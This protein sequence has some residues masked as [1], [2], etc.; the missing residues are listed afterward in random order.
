ML[1][2]H[3]QQYNG[4]TVMT[5]AHAYM[6]ATGHSIKLHGSV[7]LEQDLYYTPAHSTFFLMENEC[8]T[9]AGESQ[10]RNWQYA[11]TAGKKKSI[12][13]AAYMLITYNATINAKDGGGK[14]STGGFWWLFDVEA[15]NNPTKP[16]NGFFQN[17]TEPPFQK[18]KG[19]GELVLWLVWYRSGCLIGFPTHPLRVCVFQGFCVNWGGP[20]EWLVL[21][22]QD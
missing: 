3:V 6:D 12:V 22:G 10:K 19:P 20:F 11:A 15:G 21:L 4:A 7:L 9:V 13:I 18:I 2:L 5:Y 1:I 8:M 14:L 16:Y 17:P